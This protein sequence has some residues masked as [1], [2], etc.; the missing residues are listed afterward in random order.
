VTKLLH[1]V[2]KTFFLCMKVPITGERVPGHVP[3]IPNPVYSKKEGA[4]G[5]TNPLECRPIVESGSKPGAG[6][7]NNSFPLLIFL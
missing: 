6:L 3:L 7:L 4:A 5:Y 1:L 2:K